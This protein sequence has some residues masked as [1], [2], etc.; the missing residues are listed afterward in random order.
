[1]GDEMRRQDIDVVLV[2]P[3]VGVV[4]GDFDDAFVPKRHG[5]DNA[6]RLGSRGQVLLGPP[7]G[8]IEGVAQYPVDALTGKHALLHGHLF[9]GVPIEAAADL[10][11]YAL[12]VLAHA[13]EVDVARLAAGKRRRHSSE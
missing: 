13:Q 3:H 10:G 5:V 4:L 9:G 8:L 11:I 2:P 1:M 7:P 6:V 12:V